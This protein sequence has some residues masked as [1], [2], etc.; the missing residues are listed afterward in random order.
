MEKTSDLNE[1][2]LNETGRIFYG[3]EDQIAERSWNYGQVPQKMGEFPPP[4]TPPKK[5][6]ATLK[7]VREMGRGL[8]KCS[9][10]PKMGGYPKTGDPKFGGYPKR[11]GGVSL[12]SS[13][14]S[15]KPPRGCFKIIKDPQNNTGGPRN[16]FSFFFFLRSSFLRGVG[17]FWG[18]LEGFGGQL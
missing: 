4:P 9:G 1:Y 13:W 18:G 6:G 5:I 15:L 14:G 7:S 16:R 2:V 3:T 12:K 17:D 8:L 10:H 11:Y